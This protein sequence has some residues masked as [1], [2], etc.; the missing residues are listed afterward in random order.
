MKKIRNK[1]QEYRRNNRNFIIASKANKI[2]DSNAGETA[3]SV[4]IETSDNTLISDSYK[5]NRKGT[6]NLNKLLDKLDV[7]IDWVNNFY[8][9]HKK[10][11]L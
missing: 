1:Y 6:N 8:I 11:F 7:T 5:T 3:D 10:R 9:N 4:A 2:T